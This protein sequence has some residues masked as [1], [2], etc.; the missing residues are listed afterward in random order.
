MTAEVAAT[1]EGEIDDGVHQFPI[2]VYY[3]DTDAIG[4]VY[5]AN[6]LRFAERARTEMLRCLGFAHGELRDTRGVTFA[7]RGCQI[8]YRAPA[9]LDDRLMVRTR[10]LR[11]GGASADLEQ[12]IW[13]DD[14]LLVDVVIRLVLLDGRQRVA[15]L[16]PPLRLVLERLRQAAPGEASGGTRSIPRL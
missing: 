12:Q 15:R 6:H 1:T 2:R 11:V 4:L 10:L 9:R 8:D 7:V 3:E 14:R 5:H 16:P 13:R